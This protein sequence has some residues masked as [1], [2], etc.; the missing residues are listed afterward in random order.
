MHKS[1]DIKKWHEN[2][3]LLS[4]KKLF[5]LRNNGKCK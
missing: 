5:L 1:I 3:V 2:D 4:I